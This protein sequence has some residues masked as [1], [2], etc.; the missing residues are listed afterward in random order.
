MWSFCVYEADRKKGK[1]VSAQT[2]KTTL[3]RE[4][5]PWLE[6]EVKKK[7]QKRLDLYV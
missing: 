7:G 6:R 3:E 4:K 1:R 5:N 2:P